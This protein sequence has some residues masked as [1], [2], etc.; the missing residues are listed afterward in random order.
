MQI[1]SKPT[2]TNPIRLILFY[3]THREHR[4]RE[5]IIHIRSKVDRS[6]GKELLFLLP[7]FTNAVQ[8]MK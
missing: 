2:K 4:L 3:S 1:S 5:R 8:R 6:Q 7:S